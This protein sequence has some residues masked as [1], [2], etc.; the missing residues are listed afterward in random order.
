MHP[1]RNVYLIDDDEIY[2]FTMKKIMELSH[3]DFKVS[4]FSNGENALANYKEAFKT[5]NT[6]SAIFLDLDMPMLDGWEFL[7]EIE[8]LNIS[9]PPK[10]YV[11]S[12][13]INPEEIMN[14]EKNHLVTEFIPKPINREKLDEIYAELESH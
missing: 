6:P 11:S 12:S 7:E 13:T 14:A 9:N 10:I 8:N 1:N 2:T 3:S 4:V 5:N